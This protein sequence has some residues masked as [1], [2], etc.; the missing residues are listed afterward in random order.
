MRDL[1]VFLKGRYFFLEK[2]EKFLIVVFLK[3]L[4]YQSQ[5]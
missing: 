3:E 4:F 2:S 5:F 1:Q